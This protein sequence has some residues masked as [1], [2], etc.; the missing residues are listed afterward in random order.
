MS[1]V[2]EIEKA[3][4]ALPWTE[5]LK[6]YRDLPALIGSKPE[7]L[8]WQRAALENFFLDDSSQD[9]AYD[10]LSARRSCLP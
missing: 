9:A 7:D 5:R 8:A 4:E 3:I 2:Q 1:T 6:V 10:Q